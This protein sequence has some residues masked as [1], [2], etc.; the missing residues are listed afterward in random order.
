MVAHS[1]EVNLF[2]IYYLSSFHLYILDIFL[3]VNLIFYC[4]G[5][6]RIGEIVEI[7]PG[8]V[9][10]DKDTGKQTA[11]PIISKVVSLFSE[12]HPLKTAIPGGTNPLL[13]FSL[14]LFYLSLFHLLSCVLTLYNSGLIAVG[15]KIDPSLSRKDSL[16]G[17][18][19]GRLNEL[20]PVFCALDIQYSLMRRVV[21]G[22]LLF[23][24]HSS[25]PPFSF[26]FDSA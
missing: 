20:P 6:I 18:V 7:R 26:L 3:I 10:T 21:G 13:S 16:V 8:I 23:C 17:Q 24:H 25:L 5:V 15:L 2:F 12:S 9:R 11:T 4:K 14:L 22:I 1:N 19:V